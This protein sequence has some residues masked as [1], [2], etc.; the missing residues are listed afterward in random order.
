[1]TSDCRTLFQEIDK[2]LSV[3]P[4]EIPEDSKFLLEIDFCQIRTASTEKQSYWVQ[5]MRAAIHAGRRVPPGKRRLQRRFSTGASVPVATATAFA[6][7]PSIP[8]GIAD[9]VTAYG[10]KPGSGSINDK[11][12][13]RQKPD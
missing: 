7:S 3:S 11:S 10:G 2:Y 1:M 9:D 8:F 12:N 6:D 5:A 13:K 4:E